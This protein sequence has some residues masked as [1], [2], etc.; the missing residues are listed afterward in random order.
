MRGLLAYLI[1]LALAAPAAAGTTYQVGPGKPYATLQEVAPLLAPGDLVEVDGDHTY[2]GD[3]VFTQAGAALAPITIRGIRVNGLRPVL[4]GGTNTVTFESPWPYTAGADWYVFEGFEVTGGSF[5]CVYHQAANLTV[6]DVVVHDCPQHGILG[7]DQGSG[8]L[9]L[10]YTEVYRCGAGDSRHQIYMATDE[11]NRPGSVFRMQHCYVHDG[12]GGNNVKSRAER[13]EIYFNWIEGAYYH[14]LEL[15]GPDPGMPAAPPREDS[16][17]VGNVLRKRN[18]TFYVV[19]FGG[20]ATGETGGRY[21]FVNN[22]V[23]ASTSAVFRLFDAIESI[24][25]HNNVFLRVDGTGV[26]IMRTV[27][28]NWT[29]GSEVIAGSNNWVQTG[30]TNLPSQWTGTL[31][32]A[33]PGFADLASGDLRPAAGSPLIDHGND[34]PQDP[35]GYP[36]PAPLF[37]PAF[38]PPLHALETPGEA[39]VRVIDGPIDVGAF[40]YGGIFADGFE[41]G[42][43]SAWSNPVPQPQPEGRPRHPTQRLDG[44][45]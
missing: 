6:R 36:F 14:E 32:G 4:S 3:V 20:D 7:A 38:Q 25:M 27:D 29:T 11:T 15:I 5:R 9:T 43:T 41:S 28:A 17:V 2:P 40:E 1:G 8:S 34:A 23:L 44:S 42:D 10:E 26:N 30:S 45:H 37:P 12:L 24:Q 13:N 39:A 22:T 31:T 33:D 19:R 35:P 21:R 16:D 18:G